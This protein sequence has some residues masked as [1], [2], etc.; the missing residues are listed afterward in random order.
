MGSAVGSSF[1]RC[2]MDWALEDV[3]RSDVKLAAALIKTDRNRLSRGRPV[4]RPTAREHEEQLPL[5]SGETE[6]RVLYSFPI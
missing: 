6:R 2:L 4:W 5:K 3:A 1:G